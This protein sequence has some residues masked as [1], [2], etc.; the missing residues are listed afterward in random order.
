MTSRVEIRRLLLR[1][2]K[3]ADVHMSTIR[4]AKPLRYEFFHE[5]LYQYVLIKF[6]LTDADRPKD[7]SF[8]A[9]AE[10]SLS[11]SMQVSPELVEQFDTAKSCDGA[12]SVMAKKV[13][14]FMA[15]QRALNIELPALESARVKTMDDL[16]AI[17]WRTLARE[18]EWHKRMSV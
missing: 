13:L 2:R 1:A 17:V 15:I 12:T 18:P 8:D 5:Q 16:S 7:D 3:L 6:L 11:K 9:L 4:D 10:L 14:L